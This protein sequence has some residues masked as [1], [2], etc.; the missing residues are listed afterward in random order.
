MTPPALSLGGAWENA[1]GD[2][3]QPD[4]GAEQAGSAFKTRPLEPN[5]NR[6]R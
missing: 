5:P 6:R 2:S 4:T 1:P 3:L